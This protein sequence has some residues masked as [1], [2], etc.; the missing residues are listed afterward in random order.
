MYKAYK[1]MLTIVCVCAVLL[2]LLLLLVLIIII[3]YITNAVVTK[4]QKKI[5][6]K[7]GIKNTLI[8]K[9]QVLKYIFFKNCLHKEL[10]LVHVIT[11]TPM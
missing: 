1:I 4:L 2:L 9:L 5:L 8:D 6:N 7:I 10:A 3:I 11:V